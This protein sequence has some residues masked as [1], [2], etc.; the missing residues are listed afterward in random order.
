[1]ITKQTEQNTTK[2]QS[3]F[4]E[5]TKALL[6]EG[7]EYNP[8]EA[9]SSLNEYFYHLHQ[10][11][12]LR[13]E[14]P[15]K[16]KNK[17]VILPVD[18]ELFEINANTREITVPASFKKTAGVEGDQVAEVIYFSIDRYFDT[19]D[20][21]NQ[22]IYIEWIGPSGDEGVSEEF[23]RDLDMIPGKIIFGWALHNEITS[24]PGPIQFAVR[25]WKKAIDKITGEE[26]GEI[27]YTLRTLPQKINIS[28]G[29]ELD[30]M[31]FDGVIK[32]SS[33]DFIYDRIVESVTGPNAY[34]PM[35]PEILEMYY[36]Y[37]DTFG[38]YLDNKDNSIDLIKSPNGNYKIY[39]NSYADG[40]VSYRLFDSEKTMSE[41]LNASDLQLVLSKD[42]KFIEGNEYWNIDGIRITEFAPGDLIANYEEAVYE[43]MATFDLSNKGTGTY[44]IEITNRV[45]IDK[46]YSYSLELNKPAPSNPTKDWVDI[47]NTDYISKVFENE[48][49][50]ETVRLELDKNLYKKYD[51]ETHSYQ[52]FKGPYNLGQ[53]IDGANEN[54]YE[55]DETSNGAE[56][57]YY[58]QITN[59]L[60]GFDEI[61]NK[62][63]LYRVTE[64]PRNFSIEN[65]SYSF[66]PYN[67]AYPNTIVVGD[68]ITFNVDTNKVLSDKIRIEV[69]YKN[70]VTG[71][72]VT[73]GEPIETLEKAYEYKVENSGY[74]KF[75][76]INILNGKESKE[77]YEIPEINVAG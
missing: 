67:E 64:Y 28:K 60:N 69:L 30:S 71:E 40:V 65:F 47:E 21:N 43:K 73:Y 26:T 50:L 29:L 75:K 53:S 34:K 36:T 59:H 52:W 6:G 42:E 7:E 77:A 41:H 18:E 70:S 62:V 31:D 48:E 45:G 9:I 14:N 10:L 66:T 35:A 4:E 16:F 32:K 2:Y 74:Y 15:S 51:E 3:L 1:M 55:I 58:L 38:S 17:F 5:A 27:T 19:M 33:Q 24:E 68:P 76:I 13:V 56:S 12:K 8:D 39:L 49:E 22:N 46:N 57:Y 25:F 20:L 11:V 63:R 54:A 72:Y 44:Q 23:I 37:D 61:G